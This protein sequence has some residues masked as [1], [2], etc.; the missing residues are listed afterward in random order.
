MLLVTLSEEQRGSHFIMAAGSAGKLGFSIEKFLKSVY[1]HWDI[2]IEPS[3]LNSPS[4][5][6]FS[7]VILRFF[8]YIPSLR[9]E[10]LLPLDFSA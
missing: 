5:L 6:S 3:K 9:R 4:V 2:C 8:F 1:T 7:F 10:S